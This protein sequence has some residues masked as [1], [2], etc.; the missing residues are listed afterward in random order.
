PYKAIIENKFIKTKQLKAGSKYIAILRFQVKSPWNEDSEDREVFLNKFTELLDT[1][2]YHLT[3][4]R[5]KELADYRQNFEC[6]KKNKK[7]S[8]AYTAI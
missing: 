2:D 6:L 4:I 7:R 1:S 3:F 8:L 5:K